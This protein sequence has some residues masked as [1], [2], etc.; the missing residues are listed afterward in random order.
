MLGTERVN[1]ESRGEAAWM[2]CRGGARGVLSGSLQDGATRWMD[3]PTDY[4]FSPV[5]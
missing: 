3:L 5:P 1:G 2:V 4:S